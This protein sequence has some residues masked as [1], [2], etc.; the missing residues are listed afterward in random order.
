IGTLAILGLAAHFGHAY[1][2]ATVDRAGLGRADS[3]GHGL[4]AR[5]LDHPADG[6]GNLPDLFLRD[7][8][9]DGIRNLLGDRFLDRPADGDGNLLDLFLGHH[10]AGRDGYLL[11]DRGRHLLA[12]RHW[13][14]LADGLRFV[15]RAVHV[16]HDR[17]RAPHLLFAQGGRAL[18]QAAIDADRLA[19]DVG[20]LHGPL[21]TLACDLLGDR[22]GH[23]D[24]LTDVAI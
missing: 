24:L 3:V 14:L 16:L 1:R 21:A 22:P 7:V 23:A 12:N 4:H 2:H 13:D 17:P 15:D 6:D 18:D 5:L 9:A 19:G 8:L 20:L 10:R 11:G